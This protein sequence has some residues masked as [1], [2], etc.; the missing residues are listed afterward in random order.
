MKVPLEE[1]NV[2]KLLNSLIL[3]HL[4]VKKHLIRIANY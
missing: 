4:Y 1:I 3:D 2:V